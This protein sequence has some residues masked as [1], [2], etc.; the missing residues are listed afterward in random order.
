MTTIPRRSRMIVLRRSNVSRVALVPLDDERRDRP[1]FSEIRS[2]ALFVQ[3]ARSNAS[4]G[5]EHAIEGTKSFIVL[6]DILPHAPAALRYAVGNR[7]R[8]HRVP[9]TSRIPN[10]Y[11]ERER[12]RD[13]RDPHRPLITVSRANHASLDDRHGDGPRGPT[14]GPLGPTDSASTLSAVGSKDRRARPYP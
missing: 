11:I 2:R 9:T 1:L 12:H 6:Y 3:L 14:R 10:Q 5:T 13:T 4:I 7:K 8:P